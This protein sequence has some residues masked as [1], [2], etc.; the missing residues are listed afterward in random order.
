LAEFPRLRPVS[1]CAVLV[2]FAETLSDSAHEAVLALDRALGEEAL[3][4]QTEVVPAYVSLMVVFDP[5]VTDHAAVIAGAKARI[6]HA[7]AGLGPGQEHVVGVVYDGA[8]LAEVA[9]RTG[10]RADEVIAAHTGVSYRVALFGFAPGYAYLGGGLG[11]IGLPRKEKPVR[12][13]PAGSVIIAGAQCIITTLRMPTGWWVI[14]RTDV[15]ILGP[16][17]MLF[18]VGDRVRFVP[19]GS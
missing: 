15:M 7:D 8:D 18:E 13:V 12:D 9:R 14:G 16:E 4:G 17:R 19:V 3:A 2:E 10:L 5:L 1:D 11:V 6:G